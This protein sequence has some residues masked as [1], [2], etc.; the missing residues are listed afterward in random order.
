MFFISRSIV[1]V[2]L[3]KLVTYICI[4]F[5]ENDPHRNV[6]K[7]LF[8]KKKTELVINCFLSLSGDEEILLSENCRPYQPMKL[9]VF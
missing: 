8:I 6:S 3:L 7:I 2:D 9:I 5:L 4:F 1:N